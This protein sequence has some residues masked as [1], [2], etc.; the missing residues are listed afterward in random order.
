MGQRACGRA[1]AVQPLEG[2]RLVTDHMA[3]VNEARA[4]GAVRFMI[5]FKRA[6]EGGSKQRGVL[7]GGTTHV[8][9]NL[10]HSRF[11]RLCPNADYAA[12]VADARAQDESLRVS[13]SR[14]ARM[15]VRAVSPTNAVSFMPCRGGAAATSTQETS[16][17][18]ARHS[19]PGLYHQTRR[20]TD[21]QVRPKGGPRTLWHA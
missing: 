4:W 3:L 5:P 20:S 8:A 14:H 12:L 13:A 9:A 16:E 6:C 17:V 19:R 2:L 10:L 15:H 21:T 11:E 18:R 1:S 7:A